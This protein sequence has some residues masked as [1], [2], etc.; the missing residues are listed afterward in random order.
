MVTQYLNS[1]GKL[2]LLAAIATVLPAAAAESLW[3]KYSQEAAAAYKQGNDVEAASLF[4][5]AIE[6]AKKL[7]ADDLTLAK[8]MGNLAAVLID[9][10]KLTQAEVVLK[11]ALAAKEKS[12]GKSNPEIAST[13][14]DIGVLCYQQHKYEESESCFRRVLEMD[15][16]F[17]PPNHRERVTT[18]ENYAKLLSK[19]N[20]QQESERMYGQADRIRANLNRSH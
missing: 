15:E 17:L 10:G 8:L 11:E 7:P 20:R 3:E 13:L 18:L 16:K 6:Q 1:I 2:V 4:Q 12:V 5:L 9:Q 19:L 14:N